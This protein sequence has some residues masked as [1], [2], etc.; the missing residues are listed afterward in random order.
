MGRILLLKSTKSGLSISFM[1]TM[2]VPPTVPMTGDRI[3]PALTFCAGAEDERQPRQDE[4][5][6]ADAP[7]H[8]GHIAAC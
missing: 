1:A 7:S 2:L 6:D 5:P 3:R 4:G 8:E